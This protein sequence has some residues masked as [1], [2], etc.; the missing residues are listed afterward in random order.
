MK[1]SLRVLYPLIFSCISTLRQSPIEMRFLNLNQNIRLPLYQ[2][3]EV[4]HLLKFIE[5][6]AHC[7]RPFISYRP[8]SPDFNTYKNKRLD[9]I[10]ITNDLEFVN[11]QVLPETLSDHA[12]VIA[13]IRF[14]R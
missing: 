8:E 9:W 1:K 6:S 2:V 5:N 3:K 11:Y 13:D 4:Q 12:M 14:K 7:S 10:L